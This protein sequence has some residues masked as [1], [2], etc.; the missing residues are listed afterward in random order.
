MK[1]KTMS[2]DNPG[3]DQDSSAGI[4]YKINDCG[5]SYNPVMMYEKKE[6]EVIIQKAVDSLKGKEKI[7]IVLRD[8]EDKSYEEIAEI[9]GLNIGTVKSGL[10][11]AR[12]ELRDKLRG[13]I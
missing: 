10:S 9:T 1:K 6:R 5:N 8:I 4:G 13:V 3:I 12:Q 11:R 7:L 2:L